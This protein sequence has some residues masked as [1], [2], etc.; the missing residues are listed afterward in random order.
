MTDSPEHPFDE[1][2]FAIY[3]LS[4]D[5]LERAKQWG[6]QIAYQC[7]IAQFGLVGLRQLLFRPTPPL[8]VDMVVGASVVL[9]T[10][11][12]ALY[13][14]G[15]DRSIQKFRGRVTRCQEQLSERGRAILGPPDVDKLQWP[16]AP[17]VWLS[18]ALAIALLVAAI[19]LP[20]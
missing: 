1:E 9:V 16:L 11:A 13:I 17:V 19:R 4:T 10:G 6:W 18:G 5:D 2:V 15:T 12:A 7:V 14:A 20:E 3:Q 8:W